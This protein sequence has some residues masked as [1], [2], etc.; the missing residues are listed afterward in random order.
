MTAIFSTATADEASEIAAL[1]GAAAEDLT[2]RFGRG[3]WSSI[4]S[5]RGVLY[6]MRYAKLL[7]A[8]SSAGELLGVLR[9]AT[10]KPWAI[11]PAYFTPCRK[12]L[13][14]TDMA[15]APEAQGRGLGRALLWQA[16]ALAKS[17]PADS[18]R[19][20]AYDAPAGAGG[21]YAKCGLEERGRVVY[22]NTALIYFEWRL[23]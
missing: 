2:K 3:H 16:H 12:A 4:P 23:G 21:F 19:L 1:R 22:R 8:R 13:Y 15:V 9:L 7:L 17:W 11:D 14:L 20:D 18:V 10:K 5:E 6:S